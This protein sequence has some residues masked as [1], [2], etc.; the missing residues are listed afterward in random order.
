[1]NII[2]NIGLKVDK[3]SIRCNLVEREDCYEGVFVT[4]GFRPEDIEVK[5]FE[6]RSVVKVNAYNSRSKYFGGLIQDNKYGKISLPKTVEIE[7]DDVEALY[8]EGLLKVS[9]PKKD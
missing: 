6:E 9:V 7:T 1:M 5:V 8:E 2:E 3:N 4:P